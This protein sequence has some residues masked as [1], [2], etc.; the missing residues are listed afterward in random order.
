MYLEED[1]NEKVY[2][3]DPALRIIMEREREIRAF[4]PEQFFVI[5]AEVKGKKGNAFTVT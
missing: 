2:R 4:V 5:T 1:V 3:D